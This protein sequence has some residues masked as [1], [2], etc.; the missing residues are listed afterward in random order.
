M[1]L[2]LIKVLTNKVVKCYKIGVLILP[3]VLLIYL[4]LIMY[5][6]KNFYNV[7][8]EAKGILTLINKSFFIININILIIKVVEK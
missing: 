4:S 3:R 2:Q 1:D 7:T 5:A 8:F 6:F